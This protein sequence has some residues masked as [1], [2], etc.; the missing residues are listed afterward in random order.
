MKS[1]LT[2]L[3]ILALA[4]VCQAQQRKTDDSLLLEY[5]QGQRF[6]DALTYLK[7]IY[8]EPVADTKELS[9][10]AYTANMARLLP[11]AESYYQRIYDQDSVNLTVLYNIASINQ[12]RGNYNKA[13]FYFKSW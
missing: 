2:L 1:I 6:A 3:V 5:Y 12:R 11:E 7:S 8:A 13:E 9:R 10:L 4:T